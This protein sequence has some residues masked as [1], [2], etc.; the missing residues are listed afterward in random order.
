MNYHVHDLY[1]YTLVVN[2]SVTICNRPCFLQ[3]IWA[4]KIL[5]LDQPADLRRCQVPFKKANLI[6]VKGETLDSSA[7]LVKCILS[8]RL[9]FS[10]EAIFRMK[11]N[12]MQEKGC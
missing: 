7:A 6:S 9:D 3:L 11:I 10:R 1:T 4:M 5:T 12:V 2:S 8:R